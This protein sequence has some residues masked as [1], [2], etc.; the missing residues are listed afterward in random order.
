M[1][2]IQLPGP[3]AAMAIAAAVSVYSAAFANLSDVWR[4]IFCGITIVFILATLY[5]EKMHVRARSGK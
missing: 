1:V 4:G 5:I 3:G 2:D